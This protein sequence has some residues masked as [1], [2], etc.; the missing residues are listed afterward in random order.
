MWPP[1][2]RVL[3][4]RSFRSFIYIY[5]QSVFSSLRVFLL[6]LLLSQHLL[7][8]P[9]LFSFEQKPVVVYRA[10]ERHTNSISN[11]LSR[12]YSSFACI[13]VYIRELGGEEQH[14]LFSWP[15]QGSGTRI[16]TPSHN[17]FLV[18]RERSSFFECSYM[19]RDGIA[20]DRIFS[21]PRN[22]MSNR[23]HSQQRYFRYICSDKHLTRK[24]IA[25]F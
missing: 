18:L 25:I 14:L 8:L 1:R 7:E 11:L 23:F 3:I 5:K 15:P 2:K 10:T 6:L 12:L 9:S 22:A 17:R 4:S 19:S 20:E 13:Y 24:Y 16:R 21:A